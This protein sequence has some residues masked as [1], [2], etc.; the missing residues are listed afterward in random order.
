MPNGHVPSDTYFLRKSVRRLEKRIETLELRI[1]K[2]FVGT[3]VALK[4]LEELVDILANV[5]PR[6]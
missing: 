1:D 6:P 4:G 3:C 5:Q 2:N